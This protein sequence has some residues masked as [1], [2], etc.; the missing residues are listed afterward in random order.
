MR[1]SFA[2]NLLNAGVSDVKVAKWLGHADTKMVHLHYG[3]LL[4][5]DDCIN[6]KATPAV[7]AN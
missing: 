7:S 1:H 5:Y 3:H 4:G 2:S 6:Q